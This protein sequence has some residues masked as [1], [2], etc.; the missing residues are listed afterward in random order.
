M[1]DA[2]KITMLIVWLYI[3]T[4]FLISPLP[5]T[6]HVFGCCFAALLCYAVI[7]IL[8]GRCK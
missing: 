5:I 7:D 3:G 8:N 1:T 4:L 2:I 6:K